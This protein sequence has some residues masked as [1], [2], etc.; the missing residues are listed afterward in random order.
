MKEIN[1][2]NKEK[3]E[4]VMSTWK[5]T[6]RNSAKGGYKK[7]LFY[8]E[9]ENALKVK[10]K[11]YYT[12]KD[13]LDRYLEETTNKSSYQAMSIIKT[14]MNKLFRELGINYQFEAISSKQ[15]IRNTDFYSKEEVKQ[16]A[17]LTRNA[18]DRFIIY[19]LFSG[20]KGS[21]F[22]E[23]LDLKTKDIDF[24][25]NLIKI[26]NRKIEMD[27]FMTMIAKDTVNQEIYYKKGEKENTSK[28][29]MFYELNMH[30][31]YVLKPKPY[32]KN[33]KGLKPFSL[34]GFKTKLEK[35]SAD[36]EGS[37]FYPVLADKLY[38]SGI[39]YKMKE[40]EEETGIVWKNKNLDDWKKT[41]GLIFGTSE[42]LNIYRQMN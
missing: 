5:P 1:I 36:L 22:C 30:S 8:L 9:R 31:E 20:L 35:I 34:C 11:N 7:L 41:E 42:I 33:N 10:G 2:Y 13:M 40:I 3:V 28:S 23:L 19:G 39:L 17:L 16:I 14:Y 4:Q 18:Q 27:E 15:Y 6:A 26:N 24:K 37:S 25:H 21:K 12:T 32:S 38:K 29:S